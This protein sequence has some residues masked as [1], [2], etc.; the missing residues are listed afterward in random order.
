MVG[1]DKMEIRDIPM[2]EP[3]EKEVLVEMEYVG[4]CGS[5]VHYFHDGRCGS[6]VVEGDFML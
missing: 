6:Y 5:D 4:I 1:L 2:P 3:K